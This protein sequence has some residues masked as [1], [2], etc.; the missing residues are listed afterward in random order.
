M[1]RHRAPRRRGHDPQPPP[2]APATDYNP[3]TNPE[4]TEPPWR[5]ALR[6]VPTAEDVLADPPPDPVQVLPAV[7]EIHLIYGNGHRMRVPIEDGMVVSLSCIDGQPRI[8]V[9]L[10]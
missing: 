2:A 6:I 8:G 5:R 7:P 9:N 10:A 4:M 1:G 3:P